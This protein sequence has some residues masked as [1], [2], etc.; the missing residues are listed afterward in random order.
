MCLKGLLKTTKPDSG[1]AIFAP[2]LEPRIFRELIKSSGYCSA[3]S[4]YEHRQVKGIETVGTRIRR[5]TGE[6]NVLC[7]KIIKRQVN[8]D[9]HY[10]FTSCPVSKKWGQDLIKEV[11]YC[12]FVYSSANLLR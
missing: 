9:S 4:D 7:R 11:Q 2:R 1:Q 8:V 12:S 3:I 10:S 5:D 6:V